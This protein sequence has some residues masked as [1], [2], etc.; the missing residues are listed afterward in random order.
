MNIKIEDMYGGVDLS[1]KLSD[2]EKNIYE[3]IHNKLIESGYI[4]KKGRYYY[5]GRGKEK[6]IIGISEYNGFGIR[7]RLPKLPDYSSNISELSEHVKGC[8]LNGK[9]CYYQNCCFAKNNNLETCKQEYIFEYKDK[10]YIKCKLAY[11]NFKFYKLSEEDIP[12]LIKL[13]DYEVALLKTKL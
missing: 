8:I 5:N 3:D 12:S 4:C 7:M 6:V 13:I 1:D 11:E 10:Q 9:D 2:S